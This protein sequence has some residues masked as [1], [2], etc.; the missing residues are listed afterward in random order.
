MD[1]NHSLFLL[2]VVFRDQEC[3]KPD[4]DK[5]WHLHRLLLGQLGTKLGP[6]AGVANLS[7]VVTN[8][9]NGLMP[10]ILKLLSLLKTTR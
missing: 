9:Q 10:G 2:T 5:F 6:T 7:R 1:A 8:Q 3:G 4:P